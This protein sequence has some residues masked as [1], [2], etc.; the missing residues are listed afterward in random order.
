AGDTQHRRIDVERID[1][2]REAKERRDRDVG[3]EALGLEERWR[4]RGW[5]GQRSVLDRQLERPRLEGDAAERQLAAEDALRRVLRL[6]RDD[7]RHVEPGG[8]PE[9]R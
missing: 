4:A 7:R 8:A 6:R 1:D 2:R 3:V 9:Q 5:P